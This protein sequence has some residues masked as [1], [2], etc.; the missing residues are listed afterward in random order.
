[1]TQANGFPGRHKSIGRS[2]KTIG[3]KSELMNR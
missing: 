1:M 2:G 3:K